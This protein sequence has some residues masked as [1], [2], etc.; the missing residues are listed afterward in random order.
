VSLSDRLLALAP[1][2]SEPRILTLDI[3][4]SPA[5]VYAYGLFD[6]NIGI[7]Q[8][9][10]P[11]RVLCFAAKWHHANKVH[12]HD[13]REGR[14][15]MVTAA[16]HL[17]DEA[18]VVVGYNHV[19]FDIPHLNRE[20]LTCGLGPPSPWVDVDLLSVAR[21]RFK[22]LSNK[23]GYV[24]E[25]T[26]LPTKLDTGGMSLWRDV[27][28]GDER[29]WA[30]FIRYCANDVRIT[31]QLFDLLRDWIT[32]PHAGQWTRDRECCFRCGSS[33][34]TLI[35]LVYGKTTAYPKLSCDDCGAWNKVLRNGDTR[36]A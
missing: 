1:R 15:A 27:L 18:D 20:F 12:T 32:I 14:E 33:C 13:E 10:E 9:V 23:L 16:W 6:Q 28:A 4:T 36:P 3:E 11:S 30:K 24:T 5:L 21:R 22:F 34:L 7:S 2:H 29:A 19:R 25:A 31:E 26:G 8:I 35:G 17:L